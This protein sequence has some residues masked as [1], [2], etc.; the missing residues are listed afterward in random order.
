M[1][2]FTPPAGEPIILFILLRKPPLAEF[3]YKLITKQKALSMA[4]D[5]DMG[6]KADNQP[7]FDYIREHLPFTELG[8]E[9]GGRWIH[10]AYD[11]DHLDKEVFFA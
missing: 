11:P 3:L 9:G 1:I 7:L 4:A 6:G 2:R 5:I 10:V 8:W